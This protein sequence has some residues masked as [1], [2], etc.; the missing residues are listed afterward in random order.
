VN[1][2]ALYVRGTPD[3]KARALGNLL[4]DDTVPALDDTSNP[5]WIK[6]RR[7]DG[8]T[9]WCSKNYLQLIG[10]ARPPSV[11]QNLFRGVKYQRNEVT[12]PQIF[13]ASE[14]ILSD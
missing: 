4:K 5:E 10:D 3:P 9:G 12:D 11:R 13:D 1:T 6:I 8:L 2:S 7:L 14:K